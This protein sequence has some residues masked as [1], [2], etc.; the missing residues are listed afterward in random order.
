VKSVPKDVS[1]HRPV[2]E[3]G[4]MDELLQQFTEALAG[5]RELG[6]EALL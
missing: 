1:P 6:R 2:G 4:Q 3:V 5:Q